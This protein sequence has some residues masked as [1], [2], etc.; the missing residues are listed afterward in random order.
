MS[1]V[2]LCIFLQEVNNQTSIWYL[3]LY[4]WWWMECF[5]GLSCTGSIIY[6]NYDLA[7]LC[8]SRSANFFGQDTNCFIQ[9]FTFQNHL[10]HRQCTRCLHG[11]IKIIFTASSHPGRDPFLSWAAFLMYM[12][13]L[14]RR[15]GASF[16]TLCRPRKECLRSMHYVF[17]YITSLLP[18]L[19]DDDV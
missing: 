6:P 19:L 16:Y 11:H 3:S 17:G 12:S 10:S 7:K 2:F 4:I 8:T 1:W 9:S 18:S 14:Q 13:T 5:H 15:S